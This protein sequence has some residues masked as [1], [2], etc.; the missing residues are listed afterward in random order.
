CRGPSRYLGFLEFQKKTKLSGSRWFLPAGLRTLSILFRVVW[1][2]CP[3]LSLGLRCLGRL[4]GKLVV[5]PLAVPV[6]WM[7]TML[8]FEEGR[9]NQR[10]SDNILRICRVS[11]LFQISFRVCKSEYLIL[12]TM[13]RS[14][15]SSSFTPSRWA[16][17]RLRFSA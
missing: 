16:S 11:G 9:S 2:R 4:S 3:V 17:F 13:F 1:R 5:V 12:E 14:D 6:P 10:N 7:V 8:P 15:T